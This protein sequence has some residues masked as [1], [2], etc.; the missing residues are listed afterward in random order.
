MSAEGETRRE[1]EGASDRVVGSGLTRREASAPGSTRREGEAPGP[2]FTRAL[3]AELAEHYR[4]LRELAA[5][6]AESDVV[7]AEELSSARHVVIKLYRRGI[8]PD[9]EALARLAQASR[10]PGHDHLVEV[11]RFG[12]TASGWFEVQEHCAPGSLRDLMVSGR[13]PA[14]AEVAREVATALSFAQGPGLRVVHRDL[15]PENVFVRDVSPLDLVL[16]D[17]GVAR[18]LDATMRFTRAWGT[19]AYSPPEA[20]AGIVSDAWDWW[21][22]GMILAE[23]AGG[24]H[25]FDLSDGTMA[26]PRQ[27]R[28]MLARPVDLSALSD[29]R[30]MLLCR[31]LLTRDREQRWG[32]EQV[33]DWLDGGSPQVVAEHVGTE[34]ASRVR[35]VFFANAEY[36][37]P[38]SL[39]AA[40]TE[41]WA[42]AQQ[43]LFQVRDSRLIE[44]TDRLLRQH[45]LEEAS[46]LLS[47][48]PSASDLP[49]R[50]ADLLVEMDPERN[51]VYAGVSLDPVGLEAAA[52]AVITAGGEHPAASVLDEVRRAGVLIS[53]RTLP[54]MVRGPAVQEAWGGAIQ[55][56]EAAAAALKV[57]DF[58][59]G[60]TDNA[61]AW[62][63]LLACTLKSSYI[64]DLTSLVAS[65]DTVEAGCQTWWANLLA[66][67]TS[68]VMLVLT[69]ITHPTAVTQTHR[70]EE[71]AKQREEVAKQREDHERARSAQNFRLVQLT[72]EIARLKKRS[73]VLPQFKISL[74]MFFYYSVLMFIIL[75]LALLPVLWITGIYRPTGNDYSA[76]SHIL[77]LISPVLTGVITIG[78]NVGFDKRGYLEREIARCS[79]EIVRISGNEG[80]TD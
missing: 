44:E 19:P 3:P 21:S 11:V 69:L 78:L 39:A 47:S 20:E 66:H 1:D 57:D 17:F 41:H 30:V 67:A 33:A 7:V 23:L 54:G 8:A 62:A 61:L 40:L 71:V 22:L 76:A 75:F 74:G 77:L 65:L 51:P 34:V 59:P 72:R 35:Q 80:S 49:R 70:E 63:W 36:S 79:A 60:V 38:V 48:T 14:V 18:A 9:E 29:S 56:F 10:G 68:P 45:H 25:P 2:G 16:G 43:R 52:V 12:E 6:G 13:R 28:A 42:E 55:D 31:G 58:R 50:F 5:T 37:S 26:D 32:A 4:L 46:R 15:K 27:I 64:K 53:W 73:R 24:C